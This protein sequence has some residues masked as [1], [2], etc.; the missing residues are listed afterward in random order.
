MNFPT[1]PFSRR[2]KSCSCAI[3]ISIATLLVLA[4]PLAAQKPCCRCEVKPTIECEYCRQRVRT[5]SGFARAWKQ[6]LSEAHARK[7]DWGVLVA[8]RDTGET[9]FDLNADRYFTPASNAKLFTSVFALATLGTGLSLSHHP[10]INHPLG[11]DG[12]LS[13]DL[14][15]R[16]AGRSRSFES[17]ISFPGKS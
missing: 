4:R 17:Q 14:L 6:L 7:A 16:W 13:G 1:S 8:N 15:L 10:R 12:R 5:S 2:A 11:S 9:L 3:A